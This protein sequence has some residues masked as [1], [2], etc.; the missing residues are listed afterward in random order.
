MPSFIHSKRVKT[1]TVV[2][3]SA[4][5]AMAWLPAGEDRRRLTPAV[6]IIYFEAW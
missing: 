5:W 2:T 1:E 6:A 3:D 4:N